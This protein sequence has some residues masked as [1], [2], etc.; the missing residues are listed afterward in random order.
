M[1]VGISCACMPAFSKMV[2]QHLPTLEKLRSMLST[3]FDSLR[4]TK[5]GDTTGRYGVSQSNG[6]IHQPVTKSSPE[7]YSH[8]E[9]ETPS[10]GHAA[11]Q[12]TYEL[13]QLQSVQTVIG[14]GLK[15]GASDDQIHLTHEIQQQR[16]RH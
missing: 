13:G 12:P 10:P 9:V 1:F 14:K 6:P 8:P 5:S 15:K 4:S 7:P 11:Y 3:R 16:T 2:H